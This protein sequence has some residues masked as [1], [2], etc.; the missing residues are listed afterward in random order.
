[1]DIALDTRVL[2]ELDR[3]FAPGAIQGE[4]H[5]ARVRHLAAD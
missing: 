3:I 2:A 1:M 5:P 4:R